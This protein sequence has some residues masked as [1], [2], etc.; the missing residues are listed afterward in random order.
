MREEILCGLQ[1]IY[2]L[3]SDK[4]EAVDDVSP[5]NPSNIVKRWDGK[6]GILV[7]PNFKG[8]S[9]G[10]DLGPCH[11]L[12]EQERRAVLILDENAMDSLRK[13]MVLQPGEKPLNTYEVT[14]KGPKPGLVDSPEYST[15]LGSRSSDTHTVTV[16]A[17]DWEINYDRLFFYGPEKNAEGLHTETIHMF[18][19]GT[20]TQLRKVAS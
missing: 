1:L 18:D 14:V 10:T 7:G 17:S 20:W 9:I 11:I 5:I 6:I 12:T 13:I 3:R 19:K 4:I 15:G 8:E 16:V 2:N